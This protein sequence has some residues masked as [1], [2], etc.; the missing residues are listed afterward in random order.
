VKSSIFKARCL[1]AL[2][3]KLDAMEARMFQLE[4]KAAET[5]KPE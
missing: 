2:A 5:T 1:F 4:A 3:K